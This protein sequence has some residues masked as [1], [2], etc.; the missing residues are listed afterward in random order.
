MSVS[1]YYY[2]SGVRSDIVT[3]NIEGDELVIFFDQ[4]GTSKRVHRSEMTTRTKLAGLPREVSLDG[5]DLLMWSSSPEEDAWLDKNQLVGVSKLESKK[6]Y[7]MAS[8]ILVPLLLYGL[9]TQ[10]LPRI[11]VSFS[12]Y[13][14]YS[15]KEIGSQHTLAALDSTLLKPSKLST[16]SKELH[17]NSFYSL[18]AQIETEN[19]NYRVHFR[20]S[21]VLGPNAF[22]LPDGTIVF[23]DQLIALV[24]ENQDV[25]NAIFLH[26]VG[27]V[28]NNHS[29]QLIAE[30][31]FAT[32][33]I[34]YFFGDLSGVL[35]GVLGI[36]TSVVQN[37][38]SKAHEWEADNYAI[39]QLKAL[40][41]DPADFAAAME[42][43]QTLATEQSDLD[44]WF[45]SHPLVTDR[46]D[47]AR[48]TK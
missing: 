25:L 21:N 13:V 26:E 33:A 5:G 14:P 4:N 47:N 44:S 18:L 39:G 29:M 7:L 9:F 17:A 3:C 37:Q 2:A 45:S 24:E 6:P 1:H 41:K 34:S 32:L 20:H 42:A 27:H 36:G 15:I 22:A 12:Q 10:A 48:R 16:E 40:G 31:L 23:T 30:S 46:I 8:I 11:A 43:F 19:K 28:E 35:D 38:F